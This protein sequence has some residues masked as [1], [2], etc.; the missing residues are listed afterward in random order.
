MLQEIYINN[1]VLID[2]A[3]IAFNEGLNV[4]TGE[5]GAGKSIVVDALGLVLGDRMKNEYIRD[6]RHKLLTEAVFDL[7]F[8]PEAR[9]LL[10]ENG[11]AEDDGDAETLVITREIQSGG[12]SISRINGRIINASLLRSLSPFLIDMHL[13]N[14]RHNI[15]K[16]SNYLDYVDSFAGDIKEERSG[17]ARLYQ[18]ISTIRDSIDRIRSQQHQRAERL[19][20]LEYQ[21]KELEALGLNAGEEEELQEKRERVRDAALYSDSCRKLYNLIYSG[22]GCAYGQLYD[23]INLASRLERDP[24]FHSLLEPLNGIYFSLEELGGKLARFKQSLD[25]EPGTLDRIE[26]RLFELSRIRKKYGRTVEDLIE[27]H[28]EAVKERNELVNSEERE[29]EYEKQLA[30][31]L[32]EYDSYAKL[33]GTKRAQAAGQLKKMVHQE[34]SGMNM[35]HLRFEVELKSSSMPGPGGYE[36]VEFLFSANPGEELH[37]L[38]KIASGGELS[39]FILALKKVLAEAYLV[40]TMV[41]DEID[42]GMGGSALQT[43]ALKLAELAQGRQLIVI[44][45]APQI[46]SYANTHYLID[47][48]VKNNRTSTIISCLEKNERAKE[49]ARML[50]GE[51]Y[52]ELAMQTSW[53][54]IDKAARVIYD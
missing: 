41:F 21:I 20:F 30:N 31:S 19:D 12:K 48:Q 50:G 11:L 14:A 45:H 49:L 10:L 22:D 46:A 13:Q 51:D 3:R 39:R 24:F 44:T 2:E 27:Y 33:L 16:P 38:H 42:S 54:M 17:I 4:L 15:L 8:N 25:F 37:P 23:A 6:E 43:M 40:P 53:E 32:Q 52:S 34:L 26:E 1:F 47:K 28:R 36:S 9:N 18:E 35:P 29:V 5:T 7:K